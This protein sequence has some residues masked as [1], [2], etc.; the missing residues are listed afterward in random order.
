M[1]HAHAELINKA[2][3]NLSET[4][5]I[6]LW[7]VVAVFIAITL[8]SFV[9]SYK[10]FR[11]RDDAKKHQIATTPDSLDPFQSKSKRF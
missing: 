3:A 6:V 1:M 11:E 2:A 4:M 10:F 8:V 7:A 9:F 5:L